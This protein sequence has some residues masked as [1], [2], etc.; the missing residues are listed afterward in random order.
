M[1]GVGLIGSAGRSSFRELD[2]ML[3]SRT[4]AHEPRVVA[5]HVTSS[6]HLVVAAPRRARTTRAL[7][8]LVALAW[9]L[10]ASSSDAALIRGTG[11]FSGSAFADDFASATP[12]LATVP[13]SFTFVYDDSATPLDGVLL[14]A[15]E[16]ASATV[17]SVSFSSAN[18]GVQLTFSN[19]ALTQVVWGGSLGG[20]SGIARSTDDVFVSMSLTAMNTMVYT[21]AS[22]TGRFR[23]NP[24]AL[25]GSL[26]F[27]AVP[28]P[29][30]LALLAAGSLGL[31]RFGRHPNARRD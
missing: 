16:T 18:T 30:P 1:Q 3:A 17:G 5:P 6:A 23:S 22:S 20:V 28:E 21:L 10:V 7:C 8:N 31:A 26:S 12:P 13:G 24:P 14:L 9:V 11:V 25:T 27:A 4:R 15:A 29:A 19:G 2:A